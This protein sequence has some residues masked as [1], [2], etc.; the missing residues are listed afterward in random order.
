MVV[1]FVSLGCKKQAGSKGPDPTDI[2]YTNIQAINPDSTVNIIVEI[3]SGTTAKYEMNKYTYQLEMDSINGKP[4]YINYLGYP[5]NYG[6]IPNTM[7]AKSEGGDGDP[8]DI[9]VLGGSLERGSIHAVR[10]IGVLQLLD[11]GEQDDKIIGVIPNSNWEGVTSINN[12]KTEYKG[13]IEIIELFFSNY[14]GKGQMK[15]LGW[16][17][18]DAAWSIISRSTR[19]SKN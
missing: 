1:V 3:P 12:L 17:G 5:G 2:S 6:M 16:T 11:N 18:K 9:L 14:K 7:L 13:V 19:S 4:R 15:I 8:L 10:V